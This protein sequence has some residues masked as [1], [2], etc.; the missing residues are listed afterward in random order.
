MIPVPPQARRPSSEISTMPTFAKNTVATIIPSLRYRDA[1]A[2]IDWLCRAFGFQKHL[3]HAEG[4][5]VHHAQLTF[6]NGM[7]MLGSAD[8]TNEWSKRFVQPGEIGGRQTQCACVI[9]ADADA[10]YAHAKAAGAVIVDEL[11]AKDYGG[12]G[13][14]CRDPEGHMW[15]F[16]TYDPWVAE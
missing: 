16:G 1:L 13:Y 15:W 2:A 7:I 11:E 9:V 10:H 4:N 3:V 8:N 5:T 14:S 12:K 6:G